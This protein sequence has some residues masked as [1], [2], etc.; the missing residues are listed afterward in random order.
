MSFDFASV[1]LG[2]L[3]DDCGS[4]K[5]INALRRPPLPIS[6]ALHYLK[7]SSIY[8]KATKDSADPIFQLLILQMGRETH[9]G[10]GLA[11]VTGLTG[12]GLVAAS[13]RAWSPD[14]SGSAPSI[15]HQWAP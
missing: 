12:A 15:A 4:H 1:P 8:L 11:K 10:G 14:S 3:S 2:P 9:R 5:L 13:P 7:G 6:R